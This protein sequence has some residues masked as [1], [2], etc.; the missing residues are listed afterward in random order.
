MLTAI[1]Y[2]L[3]ISLIV[4]IPGPATAQVPPHVPGTVCFTPQ[5]WC[6]TTAGPPGTQCACPSPYGWIAGYRG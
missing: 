6:W 4:G 3:V 2:A 1:R 5:F